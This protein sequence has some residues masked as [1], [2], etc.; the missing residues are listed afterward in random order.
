LRNWEDKLRVISETSIQ[1]A[2]SFIKTFPLREK[3]TTVSVVSFDEWAAAVGLNHP[4]SVARNATRDRINRAASSEMWRAR[5]NIPFHVRV[6]FH[7]ISYLVTAPD[8]AA[9]VKA[10][11]MP[12]KIKSFTQ[13]LRAN[14]SRQMNQVEFQTLSIQQQLGLK[15]VD[16]LAKRLES[17][18]TYATSQALIAYRE[19][20]A[21]IKLIAPDLPPAISQSLE[22]MAIDDEDEAEAENE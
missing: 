17:D 11:Q 8:D 10:A 9:E 1:D 21:E 5:G 3:G 6:K 22:A 2:E 15:Q 13:T 14:I 20:R 12:G 16:L 4:D 7:G 18:V 19:L